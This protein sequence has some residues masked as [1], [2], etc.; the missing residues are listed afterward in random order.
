MDISVT[1]FNHHLMDSDI[2]PSQSDFHAGVYVQH[3]FRTPVELFEIFIVDKVMR[4]LIEET[5]KYA[6]FKN[7]PNSR[8]S[9]EEMKYYLG[10]LILSGYNELT[11]KRFY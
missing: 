2:E 3:Q 6:L 1:P 11:G 9:I 10:I 7:C 8:V 4:L 5:S